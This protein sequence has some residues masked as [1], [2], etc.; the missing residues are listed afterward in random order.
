[1]RSQGEAPDPTQLVRSS[2][3]TRDAEEGPCE[4]TA[5]RWLSASQGESPHQ[6]STSPVITLILNFQPLELQENKCLLLKP[7]SQ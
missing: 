1:M 4:D 6:G 2:G 7:P 3:D 5:R